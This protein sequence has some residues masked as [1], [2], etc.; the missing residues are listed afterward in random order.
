MKS[1]PL[2]NGMLGWFFPK[3]MAERIKLAADDLANRCYDSL[4]RQ[5]PAGMSLAERRG[6]ARAI[7]SGWIADHLDQVLVEQGLGASL[8]DRL[9]RATVD[10]LI[11]ISV[12]EASNPIPPAN[13][14]GLA[15]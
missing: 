1:N 2:L 4:G 8:A 11:E 13:L 9:C 14:K 7:A 6:Y 3:R 10:R 5:L 15:A 12:R